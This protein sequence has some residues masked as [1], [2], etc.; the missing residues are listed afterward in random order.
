MRAMV[1]GLTMVLALAA[2]SGALAA[3]RPNPAGEAKLAKRLEG[4]VAGKP[5]HC[6]SLR[7]TESSEII[8]GTAIL[9]NGLGGRIYVN[10]PRSGADSL[11][12][13]D[14]IVTRTITDQL[15]N[16]DIVTLVEPMSHFSRGFVNLGD[17]VP[18]AK[19]KP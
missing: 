3:E 12:R 9:Y 15:C 8:E 11:R 18:Y 17:F 16:T 13:D 4:R 2:A 19:P 5:V 1:R 14:I 6:I 7:P 10:R